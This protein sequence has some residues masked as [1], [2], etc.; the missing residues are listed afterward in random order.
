MAGL[1]RLTLPSARTLVVLFAFLVL[2]AHIPL[3]WPAPRALTASNPPPSSAGFERAL[4]Y[5]YHATPLCDGHLDF[6]LRFGGI[7]HLQNTLFLVVANGHTVN[8][9][10]PSQLSNAPNLK[11]LGRENT[12]YD[13][14]AYRFGIEQIAATGHRPRHYGF[15]NCGTVGPIL[16]AYLPDDYDWF[17]AFTSRFTSSVKLVGTQIVCIPKQ[18]PRVE[19]HSWFADSDAVQ[20]LMK[21]GVLADHGTKEY[22]VKKGEWALARSVLA[23]GWSI[24]SLLYKYRNVDWTDPKNAMCNDGH[25]L[26]VYG[27]L[28]GVDPFEVIFYKPYWANRPRKT[29]KGR[30]FHEVKAYMEWRTLWEDGLGA[31]PPTVEEKERIKR[32]KAEQRKEEK[33]I[34]EEEEREKAARK[35][36]KP[37]A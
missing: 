24:D 5:A 17:S 9:S 7:G 2:A 3:P 25:Y 29:R 35:A 16:P 6:F 26:Y 11:I 32:E 19:G 30:Y 22:A 27:Q 4:V 20:L 13:F 21:D 8:V 31:L 14:A 15:I 1:L 12:G 28:Q 23:N 36:G 18:G 37:V 33:E 10:V 34:E